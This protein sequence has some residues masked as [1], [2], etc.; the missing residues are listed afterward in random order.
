VRLKL[1]I[2]LTLVANA[3]TA[4]AGRTQFEPLEN[5]TIPV[6]QIEQ[7]NKEYAPVSFFK[8]TNFEYSNPADRPRKT[9]N[10]GLTIPTEILA[11]NGKK[12]ALSGYML[13]FDFKDRGVTHFA[14][15]IAD[16]C[17]Y[18]LSGS[19]NQWIEVRMARGKKSSHA[20][21]NRITV[22]GTLHVGEVLR[23]GYV[24]SFYRLTADAVAIH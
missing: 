18:G 24:D 10:E 2:T 20:N 7:L 13:A 15:G 21:F 19:P 11:M 6:S 3:V 22:L 16:I 4:L 8:L 23:D 14:L 12:V 17:H 1:L 5:A 9:P